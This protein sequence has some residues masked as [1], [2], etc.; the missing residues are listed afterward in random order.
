MKRV[1]VAALLAGAMMLPAA[2]GQARS[3]DTEYTHLRVTLTSTS[4]WAT[5]QFLGSRVVTLRVVDRSDGAAPKAW[6]KGI[7]LNGPPGSWAVADLIAD[8]SSTDQPELRLRKGSLGEATA[9]LERITDGPETLATLNNRLDRSPATVRQALDPAA[10]VAGGLQ[11]P[12]IDGRRLTLAWYYP[13]FNE[14]TFASGSWSDTPRDPEDTTDPEEVARMVDLAADNGV[15]GFITSWNGRGRNTERVDYVFAAASAR[16]DFVVAP[17]IEIAGITNHH[18]VAA[19]AVESGIRAVLERS[20]WPAYLHHESRPVV[21]MYGMSRLAPQEWTLIRDRLAADGHHPFFVGDT[22]DPAYDLD[23]VY[24]YNPNRL[25]AG[26]LRR[27]YGQRAED[28]RIPAQ[29]DPSLR[30]RLWAATV[31][32]GFDTRSSMLGSALLGTG[33]FRD[34]DGGA[35]YNAT[36]NAALDSAPEWIFVTSWNEW[37][38]STHIAP[39]DRHGSRAL[40]QTRTWSGEFRSG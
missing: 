37:Y 34:R 31:S 7:S 33:E 3:P 28:L 27:F 38:E 22:A 4:D 17:G 5:A 19:T 30:Q 9:T 16:G 20:A 36:W 35:R 18:P 29:I 26:A 13:W 21:V 32:P 23:G 8:V 24:H 14:E 39:S 25:D 40:E 10:L 12:E 11:V 6:S 1:L 15:S 2:A